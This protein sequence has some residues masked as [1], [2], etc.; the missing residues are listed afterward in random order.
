MLKPLARYLS[1][2]N[3]K[4]SLSVAIEKFVADFISLMTINL[5]SQMITV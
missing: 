3:D 2:N 1:T 5:A 4:C